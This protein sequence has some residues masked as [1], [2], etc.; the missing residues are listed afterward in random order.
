MERPKQQNVYLSELLE[1]AL[2]M[3]DE[4]RLREIRRGA[5]GSKKNLTINKI[6]TSTGVQHRTLDEYFGRRNRMPAKTADK[7]MALM[8]F[9]VLDLLRPIEVAEAI[10]RGGRPLRAHLRRRLVKLGYKSGDFS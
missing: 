5:H 9:D 4:V 3:M 10:H 8:D 2:N 6:A 7:I 1:R